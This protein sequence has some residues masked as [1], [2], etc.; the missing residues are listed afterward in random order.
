[1]KRPEGLEITLAWTQRDETVG[2]LYRVPISEIAEFPPEMRALYIAG[3][4]AE[5]FD[6]FSEAVNEEA[7]KNEQA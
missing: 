4:I 5:F 2:R 6:L 1:M 3:R 7:D